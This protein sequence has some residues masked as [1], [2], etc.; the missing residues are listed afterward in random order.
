MLETTT[1]LSN[2]LNT[3]PRPAQIAWSVAILIHS[4]TSSVIMKSQFATIHV[5]V[6]PIANWVARTATLVSVNVII[7]DRT[8]LSSRVRNQFD[9]ATIN[10][11]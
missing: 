11:F 9:Q 10:V 6:L 4:V 3:V 1:F 5:P 2:A 7:L 8:N